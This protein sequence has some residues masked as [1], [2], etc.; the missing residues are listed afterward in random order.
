MDVRQPLLHAS[1]SLLTKCHNLAVVFSEASSTAV[2]GEGKDKEE[3][4]DLPEQT[5]T[6]VSADRK[7]RTP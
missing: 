5:S 6:K 1:V 4:I 3:L 7:R 2:Y